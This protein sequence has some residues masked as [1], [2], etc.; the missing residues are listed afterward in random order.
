M[1]RTTAVIEVGIAATVYTIEQDFP[2]SIARLLSGAMRAT[3]TSVLRVGLS[4]HAGSTVNAIA[5]A[6][7]LSHGFPNWRELFNCM[8]QKGRQAI[9]ELIAVALK[10]FERS[11]LYWG[12]IP[13]L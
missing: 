7:Q 12:G 6:L 11:C 3:H 1:Y 2:G 10:K 13:Y 9:Y 4:Q 5:F 8:D